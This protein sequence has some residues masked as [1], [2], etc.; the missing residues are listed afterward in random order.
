MD[1]HK[2]YLQIKILSSNYLTLQI[3]IVCLLPPLTILI[4]H[5]LPLRFKIIGIDPIIF[6]KVTNISSQVT[7]YDIYD[8]Q[9]R[10]GSQKLSNPYIVDW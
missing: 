4:S 3:K 1:V 5:Y 2:V 6:D 10:E 8:F 9:N 7:G